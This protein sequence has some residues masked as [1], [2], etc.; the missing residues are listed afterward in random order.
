MESTVYSI[1][2]QLQASETRVV[3]CIRD[4]TYLLGFPSK[5]SVHIAGDVRWSAMV[6]TTSMS[7]LTVYDSL[8]IKRSFAGKIKGACFSRQ[9]KICHTVPGCDRNCSSLRIL[10]SLP[11]PA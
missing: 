3:F 1:G 7:V 8:G 11:M 9:Y 5:R 2:R 4:G 6:V 10:F